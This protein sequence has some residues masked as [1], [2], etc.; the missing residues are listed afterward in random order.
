LRQQRTIADAALA[1]EYQDLQITLQRI[2]LQAVV[3]E[4][5][6]RL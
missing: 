1:V 4:D 3:T 5:E 6:A 2:V